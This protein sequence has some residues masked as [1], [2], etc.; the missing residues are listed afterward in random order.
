VVLAHSWLDE[1]ECQLVSSTMSAAGVL[2]RWAGSVS[3]CMSG[4]WAVLAVGHIM[5][6]CLCGS[7]W[8]TCLLMQWIKDELCGQGN[9]RF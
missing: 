9:M 5:Y 3:I 4:G 2:A 1:E 6:T 8:T 7:S